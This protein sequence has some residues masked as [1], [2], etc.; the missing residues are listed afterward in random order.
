MMLFAS[1]TLAWVHMLHQ[2]EELGSTHAD[3]LQ[4]VMTKVT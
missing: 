4:G 1:G 2:A 3:V